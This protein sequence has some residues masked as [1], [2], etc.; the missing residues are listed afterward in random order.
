MDTG[1]LCLALENK[2]GKTWG[3]LSDD[4]L[5]MSETKNLTGKVTKVSR[6]EAEKLLEPELTQFEECLKHCIDLAFDLGKNNPYEA[7]LELLR[8]NYVNNLARIAMGDDTVTKVAFEKGRKSVIDMLPLWRI[9]ENDIFSSDC[10]DYAVIYTKDGGDHEDYDV[11]GIT[12]RVKKGE[13][14]IE[15]S[16]LMKLT[17]FKTK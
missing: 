3:F 16:D 13:K 6:K 11:V 14:Y 12:N 9:A 7:N 15:L 4:E 5:I 8:K 2:T 1:E 10:I 17:L